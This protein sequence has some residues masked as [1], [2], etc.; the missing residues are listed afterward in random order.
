MERNQEDL[1]GM[2]GLLVSHP[3]VLKLH[4]TTQSDG[5][6]TDRSPGIILDIENTGKDLIFLEILAFV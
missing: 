4:G 6:C 1:L 3:P 5:C 2:S